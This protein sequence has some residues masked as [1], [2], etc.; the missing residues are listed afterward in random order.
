MAGKPTSDAALAIEHVPQRFCPRRL[1]PGQVKR[2]FYEGPL[3]G[4]MISCPSCGF[5]E[6]HLHKDADFTEAAGEAP[7]RLTGSSRPQTCMNCRRIISIAGSV[8][9]ARSR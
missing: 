4:Y 5:I 9:M 2:Y 3:V 8:I 7:A 1:K 6:M